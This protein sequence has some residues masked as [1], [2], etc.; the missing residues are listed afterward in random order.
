MSVSA[1][2][3]LYKALASGE[4]ER[5]YLFYGDNDYLKESAA[6]QLIER[7]VDASVRDFNV[8]IR[9]GSEVD[10]EALASVLATP[11]MM[12]DRRVVV[13]RDVG[14]LKKAARGELDRY[15]KNPAADTVVVL[16]ASGAPGGS[17]SVDRGL[18]ASTT[19]VEF[20]VLSEDRIPKWIANHVTTELRGRITAEAAA[21]LLEAIGTD[22]SQL[23]AELDK[24]TSYVDGGEIDSSAVTAVVGI[25]LGETVGDLLDAVARRDAAASVALLR[26]V[27]PLPKTSGVSI[28]MALATQTLALAWGRVLRDEGRSSS[29][30]ERAYFGLL[31][32][33]GAMTGRPWG[34]AA[35]NWTR[36]LD[37]WT[38]E[39][40]DRALEALLAADVALKESRVSSEEQVL[41]TLILTICRPR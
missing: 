41:S 25:R 33:S 24:L 6:R 39:E 38:I 22:L 15:L 27:L 2:R 31:R 18:E 21:L 10:A 5:A 20:P 40:L 17:S 14:A 28:V 19:A 13:V 9:R 12:A 37:M 16:L 1:R 30:I 34:E 26:A 8:E 3:A 36:A 11:P 29:E 4:F 23:A 35:R 32:E 7:A